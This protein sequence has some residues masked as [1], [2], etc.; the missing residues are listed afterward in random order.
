MQGMISDKLIASIEK[1]ADKIIAR[2]TE[3]LSSDPATPSFSQDALQRFDAKAHMVIQE[4]GE[5]ISYDKPKEDIIR[6]YT[7][8]GVGLFRMGIP[9]CEGVRAIILLKRTIWLF[10]LESSA[11]D[12]AMELHQVRELNDRASLF[13]DRAQYNFIIGYMEEMRN[14]AKELWKLSDADTEKLF[15]KKSFYSL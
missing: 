2:W 1:N 13:F 7:Q 12:S 9:L 14:R 10:V 15:F 3:R 4:L 6:H 8:E 11:F 5:W